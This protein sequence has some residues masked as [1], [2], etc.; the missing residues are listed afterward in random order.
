[1][2]SKFKTYIIGLCLLCT[3]G[4]QANVLSDQAGVSL[5]TCTPGNETYM[6]FGHTAIR[7]YDP[8]NRI[9][10]VY[11]Y[12]IFDFNT[13]NFY[14]KFLRG[15]TWYELAESPMY[16]FRHECQR[17]D[18]TIY[19]QL[20]NLTGEEKDA[21]YLALQKNLLPE[22]KKYLYNF[23]YD[24]CATRAYN[25]ILQS[26]SLSL[27]SDYEGYTGKSYRAFLRRYAG[28]M[29]WLN[30]GINL[31]FGYKS[32]HKMTSDERLFL[33]EELMNYIQQAR[34]SDN[35]EP[36]VLQSDIAPFEPPYTPWYASWPLGLVLYFLF[37][38]GMSYYD[39]KR[40]KW[41]WWVELVPGIPYVLLLLLVGFM[42]FFSYHPLVGFG[43]RLLIIP[44]IHLCARLIYIIRW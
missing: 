26:C 9:D 4:A 23:V 7:I 22:N 6:T 39:H 27:E 38:F 1:M 16:W 5:L 21:L 3:V 35:G 43:W 28:S 41:S 36:F 30:A 33:P 19:S 13:E 15:E 20:L 34:R 2:W 37:V 14:W 25:I 11:N 10:E 12:G 17:A 42:T 29:S 18:R 40:R 32:Y 24:N 8:V 44:A 31:L